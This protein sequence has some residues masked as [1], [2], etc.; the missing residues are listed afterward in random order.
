MRTTCSVI[1]LARAE[2]HDVLH[3]GMRPCGPVGTAVLVEALVLR[4]DESGSQELWD[5]V[6]LPAIVYVPLVLVGDGE[7]PTVAVEVLDL[8]DL[9][10]R[11]RQL[12]GKRPELCAGDEGEPAAE[13]RQR[14]DGS[15]GEFLHGSGVTTSVPGTPWPKTSGSYISSAWT[16]ST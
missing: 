12:L 7:A 16:G 11:W 15:D 8:F 14:G 9:E 4:G 10:T 3:G 6:Q 13:E 5:L 2:R 1:V